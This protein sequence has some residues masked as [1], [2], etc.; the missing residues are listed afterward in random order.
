MSDPRIETT[1]VHEFRVV[2]G[3]VPTM[4]LNEIGDECM[5]IVAFLGMT[6][7]KRTDSI[8]LAEHLEQA[9]RLVRSKSK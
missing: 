1:V 3:H 2:P 8:A 7:Y 6:S 9:A 5:L 4:A